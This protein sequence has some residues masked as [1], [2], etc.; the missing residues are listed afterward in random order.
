[1]VWLVPKTGFS[2]LQVYN[3]GMGWWLKTFPEVAKLADFDLVDF[4]LI[5]S[6]DDL[7][8]VLQAFA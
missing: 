2:G 4:P 5:V 3:P 6:P 7:A 8:E 1:V